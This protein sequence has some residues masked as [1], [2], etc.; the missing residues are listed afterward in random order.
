MADGA[1]C[2]PNCLYTPNNIC[3]PWPS[4][5]ATL[6]CTIPFC[7]GKIRILVKHSVIWE[8][9][10][11]TSTWFP[12]QTWKKKVPNDGLNWG[13]SRRGC[14]GCSNDCTPGRRP[15]WPLWIWAEIEQ[16]QQTKP[17][18]VT[19]W[20]KQQ[21]VWVIPR[22]SCYDNNNS[23]CKLFRATLKPIFRKSLHEKLVNLLA[24]LSCEAQVD[25]W[26]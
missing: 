4:C 25:R 26:N 15:Q 2:I 24:I 17:S 10:L 7:C 22:G 19:R 3:W 16:K 21:W 6:H 11:K 20:R 18:I 14:W 12:F 13:F 1:T 9:R 8:A 5:K 23:W